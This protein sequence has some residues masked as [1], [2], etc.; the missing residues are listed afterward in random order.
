MSPAEIRLTLQNRRDAYLRQIEEAFAAAMRLEEQAQTDELLPTTKQ[1]CADFAQA[2]RT[3]AARW[4]REAEA[5]T[6]AL[7]LYIPPLEVIQTEGNENART[8]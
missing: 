3:R 4:A 6:G 1:S 2:H 8:A 5:L 7:D